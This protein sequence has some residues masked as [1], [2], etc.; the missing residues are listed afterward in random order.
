MNIHSLVMMQRLCYVIQERRKA[1]RAYNS[2]RIRYLALLLCFLV[3]VSYLPVTAAGNSETQKEV[4]EGETEEIAEKLLEEESEEKPEEALEDEPGMKNLS[5][6]I[7]ITK[8]TLCYVW[9]DGQLFPVPDEDLI[10]KDDKLVLHYTYEI[11][12][13]QCKEIHANTRYYLNVPAH[14]VLPSLPEGSPLEIKIEGEEKKQFGAIYADG[15]R[16]WV[17]FKENANGGTVIGDCGGI[18]DAYFYLDCERSREVPDDEV[19]IEGKTNLYKMIFEN[20]DELCFGYAENAP[21][22]NKAEVGKYAS[23][24]DRRITWKIEYTPW[25]NPSGEDGVTEETSFELRDHIDPSKHCYVKGSV[26]IDGN[27]V[28]EY[29]SRDKVPEDAETYVLFENGEDL[30]LGGTKFQ[31]GTATQGDGAVPVE[32]T[33]DTDIKEDFLLN[34]LLPGSNT[35][36]KI[37][38]TNEARLFA[39]GADNI[40]NNMQISGTYTMTVPQPIW[41]TKEGNTT[42]IPG[43]GSVTDWKVTF[44]PNGLIFT[45]EC[46]LTLHDR[47]PDGSTLVEGSAKVE[48]APV[49]VDGGNQA[50][51]SFVISCINAVEHPIT[52]TYQTSVPEEMYDNGTNLGSNTAWFTFSYG[53]EDYITPQAVR[54]VGN[55]DGTGLPGTSTLVKRN[56]GYDASTRTIEWVVEINPHKAYLKGGTFTD[57]L[58]MVGGTCNFPGHAGG[59]ELVG[60]DGRLGNVDG[61]RVNIDPALSDTDKVPVELEYDSQNRVIIVKAE[62]VGARTI[63]LTYKTI[64]CDPCIFANNTENRPFVNTVSTQDMVVGSQSDEKRIA[65]ADSTADINALVLSKKMPVYD[66]ATGKM[67]WSIEINEAGLPMSDVVLT[68]SLPDGL[69]YVDGS[70]ESTPDIS[71]TYA[72]A[73]GQQLTIGLEK[74]EGKVTVTF[75]TIANPEK[76]GFSSNGDIVV[77]NSASMEGIADGVKFEEVSNGVT[78]HFTNHGMVKKGDADIKQELI[79]YEVLINPY[80]LALP[81]NPSLIDTLDEKLQLDMDT[82]QFYEA[83]LSGTTEN[84]GQKPSYTKSGSGQPLKVDSYDPAQNSFYVQL[85]IEEGSQKA[86]VLTYTADMIKREQGNYSNQI[87][88][89]GGTVLLG[90]DKNNVISVGG[91][92]GGGGGVASR[93]AGIKIIKADSENMQKPLSGVTFTL[94]L[95]NS[96]ENERGL[97][98]A[99]GITDGK[100]ELAF[101]VKPHTVY[102]LVESEGLPGYDDEFG[103]ETLPDCVTEKGKGLL[104]EAGAAGSEV[105]LNLTNESF[106]PDVEIQLFFDSGSLM[107]GERVYLF[108]S[109]SAGQMDLASATVAVVSRNG[110]VRLSGLHRNRVYYIR[111]PG[112]EIYAIKIPANDSDR[113]T[114]KLPDGREEELTPDYRLVGSALP[115]QE[116]EKPESTGNVGNAAEGDGDREYTRIEINRAQKEFDGQGSSDNVDEAGNIRAK[117]PKTGNNTLELAAVVLL[118]GIALAGMTIY[119]FRGRKKH[120]KK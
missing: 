2:F 43:N 54:P 110:T 81:E 42:R 19:P 10:N 30:I 79:R 60:A 57:D 33:Y 20:G 38:I 93:K 114:I 89:N 15:S 32:I 52:I 92:G 77:T 11:S 116:P 101:K 86:Y 96:D 87:H 113:P 64:V 34:S 28:V 47:L 117:S 102:E 71:G 82:L 67:K 27:S 119:L 104:V 66:Y 100:G 56:N 46:M 6:Y 17:M 55:G 99:Q 26:K 13:D 29:D 73:N 103:W 39:A 72:Y 109:D 118:L 98:I 9:D 45:E 1:V 18:S 25:Q 74:I 31:A 53:G 63:T 76:I 24:K 23:L 91:G 111:L 59:L 37:Q 69:T 21:F 61:I 65:S 50:E 58:S 90:G 80:R 70:F 35:G 120:G 22:I 41:V 75:D 4:S 12:E 95:W 62:N 112:G 68:D 84:V 5:T 44:N 94:Y 48:G 85:P 83:E 3:M 115:G 14:L 40:Y 16:A 108:A 97:A 88:F 106:Y 105:K 49:G 51:E 78:Y 8:I 107:S 7:S 36:Q